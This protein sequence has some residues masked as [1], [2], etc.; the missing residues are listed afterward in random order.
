MRTLI[1]RFLMLISISLTI[2][3]PQ[4]VLGTCIGRLRY[5]FRWIWYIP[6]LS[7]NSNGAGTMV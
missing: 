6:A 5:Y 4:I 3:C 7:S 2:L 1:N